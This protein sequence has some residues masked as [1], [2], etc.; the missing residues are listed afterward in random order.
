ME[1]RYLLQII[2]R[3][4]WLFIICTAVAGGVTYINVSNEPSL[5]RTSTRL[6]IGGYT[7]NPNPGFGEISTSTELAQTYTNLVTTRPI[8]EAT[9]DNLNLN[10]GPGAL[11][12]RVSTSTLPDTSILIIAVVDSSPVLAANIANELALQLIASSPTALTPGDLERRARIEEQVNLTL[13]ELVLMQD[14]VSEIDDYIEANPNAPDRDVQL[15]RRAELSEQIL[16]AQTVVSNFNI[17]IS[18][19]RTSTNTLRVVEPAQVPGAPIPNNAFREAI[20]AGFIGLVAAAGL[21][22]IYE[23]FDDTM[24]SL[25]DLRRAT[26]LQVLAGVPQFGSRNASYKERLVVIN[27]PNSSPVQAYRSMRTNLLFGSGEEAPRRLIVTSSRAGEG[28]TVTS[29]NLAAAFAEHQLLTVLI[30]ADFYRPQ[31]HKFFETDNRVGLSSIFR[32]DAPDDLY[33]WDQLATIIQDTPEPNLKIITTG[34]RPS[35]PSQLFGLDHL[36]VLCDSLEAAGVDMIV[37]DTPPVNAV[38]DSLAISSRTEALPVIVVEAR[39][40]HRLQL[41]RTIEQFAQIENYPI[42][43]VL[44]NISARGML[45]QYYYYDYDAYISRNQR[46]RAQS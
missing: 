20:L 38:V 14:E 30:D 6:F 28:K 23:Y 25:S 44:N 15:A 19:F 21:V 43:I 35:N 10:I 27:S 3:W 39:K 18:T 24:R 4:W 41:Q 12:A 16:E 22:A 5:Y 26:D 37:F 9:I 32:Q 40:T 29:G 7:E 46:A 31:V 8:L 2:L 13:D 11:A 42:G 17:S 36:T 33:T 45:Y 34:P 1:L